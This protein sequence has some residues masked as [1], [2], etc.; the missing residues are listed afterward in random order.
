MSI[1]RVRVSFDRVDHNILLTKLKD[2]GV[3]HCLVKWFH[4]YLRFQC[5]TVRVDNQYSD[6]LYITAGMP[7]G[8]P[9]G[10]LSFL[11]LIDDLTVELTA[12]PISMWMTPL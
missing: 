12:S 3:P 9:L 8:S 6:W 1:R 7:Q 2:R 11:L 10:L 4:S 5:Q